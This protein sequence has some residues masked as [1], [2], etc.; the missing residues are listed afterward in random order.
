MTRAAVEAHLGR[1]VEEVLGPLASN[2]APMF[3]AVF[4]T[5]Q[6]LLDREILSLPAD[7]EAI[8]LQRTYLASYYPVP[9]AEGR[10]EWV[11]CIVSDV[12][13][14]RRAAEVLVQGERMEAIARVAGG[15]AHEVNNMMTVIT[16]FGGFLEGSL[17]QDDPRAEDIGE[18]RR[19]A[20]RAAGITRQLLA[21]SRQQLLQPTP[22]DLNGL[23]TQSLPVFARLLGS[24]VQL[25]FEAAP[26]PAGSCRPVAARPGSGE[27]GAQRAGRHGRR[28]HVAD[29]HRDPRHR[30]G[31]AG[32]PA[33]RPDAARPVRAPHG[34]RTPATAWTPPPRPA[35]S[36]R[37]SRPS[38]PGRAA[39]WGWRPCTAS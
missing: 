9:T 26:D 22:L 3:E 11:G 5:G 32:Q 1:T 31:P 19:A 37:S 23:L 8:Q 27:P 21:Y 6:P 28:G 18:I 4:R 10:T 38:G 14:R 13:E 12:T 33:R 16:G 25:V 2:V 29:R 20:E 7:G 36:S 15:V 35:S 24:A 17:S 39:G 34:E 30:R